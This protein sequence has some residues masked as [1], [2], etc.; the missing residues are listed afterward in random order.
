MRIDELRCN[1]EPDDQDNY[2]M[3]ELNIINNENFITD[4]EKEQPADQT[5]ESKMPNGD[6]VSLMLWGV[7]E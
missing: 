4:M 6:P 5:W 7:D 3:P 1:E 2:K